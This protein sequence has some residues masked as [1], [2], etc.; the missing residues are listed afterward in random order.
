M[1][2]FVSHP[3][4]NPASMEKREYQ[5]N[6]ARI[7]QTGNTLV[8]IP[9][10]LGKT[11]ISALVAARRLEKDMK[12]KV[13]F[14]APT[15]PLVNQ[16]RASFGKYLKIGESELIAVTGT[17]DPDI[18]KECYR[19]ADIVFATPQ[20]IGNDLK[21]G[22][23]DLRDYSLLIVDEAHRCVGSYAYV[24]VAKKY[25]QQSSSPLILALTASPGGAKEKINEIKQR[26]FIQNVEI[27]THDDHDVKPFVQEVDT[28]WV[29]VELPPRLKEIKRLLEKAK[30]EKIK[31]LI[32]WHIINSP[33]INKTQIIRMQQELA[34]RRSG[35]SYIAM[36]Y[37]AE[38]IKL[39]H[40]LLLLETQCL[41]SLKK[42]FDKLGMDAAAGKT[43]AVARLMKDENFS[44][45]VKLTDAALESSIEH[46]KIEKLK[47]LVM[48]ELQEKDA[49]IMI[50]A[51]IRDTITIIH[52]ELKKIP[53]CG[54]VEFIG[55]AKK[56]GK[57]LSQK[58]QLQILNEFKMG[59]YNV[60]IASQVGEEGIDVTETNA[61]IFYEPV[62]SAIRRIQRRGRTARTLSLVRSSQGT[63][64]E[65]DIIRHAGKVPR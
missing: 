26:L 2:E 9:T 62:P 56:S 31:K 20:T 55:Q 61:V 63:E 54:P 53:G 8:V 46:P 51:Q 29:K 32:S 50:F 16:H 41:Y 3:W 12:K 39:D 19:K 28:E 7:A 45:A 40:A 49:R 47:Q 59:F 37:L 64:N 42:Y 23:I 14:L 13:L 1:P 22:I 30:E 11:N 18:R 44:L 58:E 25:M 60:L 57:G 38:L 4:I 43:R 6:I 48:E 10:G 34:R 27:R 24:Y 5:D 52:D 17:I 65:E 21:R 15:R 35:S 33:V 36:S